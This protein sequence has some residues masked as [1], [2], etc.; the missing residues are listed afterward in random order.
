MDKP[1]N[2]SSRWLCV[3]LDLVGVADVLLL[4]TVPWTTGSQ[5]G[6]VRE[7]LETVH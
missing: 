3:R 7:T 6:D 4:A 1:A 5:A 2:S